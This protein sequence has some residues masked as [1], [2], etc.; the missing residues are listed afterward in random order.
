[1]S[2]SCNISLVKPVQFV[3]CKTFS[4]LGHRVR[5]KTKLLSVMFDDV[6]HPVLQCT[7]LIIILFSAQFIEL[8]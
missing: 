4:N 2:L 1:M 7:E 5:E 3:V 8:A 6:Y